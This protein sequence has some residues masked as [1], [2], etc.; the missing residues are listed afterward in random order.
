MPEYYNNKPLE[1]RIKETNAA[2]PLITIAIPT[3]NRAFYILQAVR[4]VIAQ[5][6]QH[7]ELF[8]ADDGSTDDTIELLRSVNDSRI[9]IL[10]LKHT[11]NIA[12]LRNTAAQAG[13]GDWIA[14]LDSDDLWPVNKLELQVAG[15][16]SSGKRW[17]YGAYELINGKGETNGRS[18]GSF[19]PISGWITENILNAEAAVS[20]GSLMVE[21]TL[22]DETGGFNTDAG[23]LYREDYD[24]ALRLS[25]KAEA[26]A[27]PDLLIRIR[28]HDKR[29]T[30]NTTDG[31]ERTA[32][33]F[34]AFIRLQ[35]GKKPEQTA[36]K[37]RGYH[38]T[39]AAGKNLS[40]KKYILALKQIYEAFK[41]GDS[42]RHIFSTL[43]S[44]II[45]RKA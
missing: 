14:F 16:Q 6:Y 29:S 38:L 25:L 44:A 22:F 10:E 45:K 9:H 35:P 40:Q 12:L 24:F 31:Y 3:H 41:D 7:W 8:V 18:H 36:R 20:I 42:T 2:A 33:A 19:Q 26:L 43:H 23:L 1:T 32:Y 30:N 21:R 13:S 28:E 17:C 39:E 5:T 34:S 11:G 15:L 27:L 4:S 37:R